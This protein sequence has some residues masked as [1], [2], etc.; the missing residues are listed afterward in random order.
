MVYKTWDYWL[1]GLCPLCSILKN[2]RFWKLDLFPSPSEEVGH[3]LCWVQ[4][5]D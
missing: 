4:S 1:F 2:T 5:S 3:I